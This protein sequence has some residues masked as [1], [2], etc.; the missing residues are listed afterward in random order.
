M[1]DKKN[2]NQKQPAQKLT[3]E[4]IAA[5]QAAKEKAAA[6]AAAE[7]ERVELYGKNVQNMS[8]RQLRAELT[9]TIRREHTKDG[10]KRVPIAG[11]TIAFATALLAVLDNTC[12]TPVT[13]GGRR[14][15]KDQLNPTA[16]RTMNP[17]W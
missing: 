5:Q 17:G 11:Q 2:R 15:R 14:L 8:H 10:G 13:D 6:D 4:E 12:T 9:K 7:R 1:S 16:T 3:P